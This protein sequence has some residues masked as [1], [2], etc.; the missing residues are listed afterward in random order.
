MD[1]PRLSNHLVGMMESGDDVVELLDVPL[2]TL[3]GLLGDSVQ[4]NA[5]R[6]RLR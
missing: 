4:L 1:N 2:R 6:I 5:P 3:V